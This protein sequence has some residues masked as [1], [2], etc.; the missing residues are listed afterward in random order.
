MPAESV[1]EKTLQEKTSSLVDE[2]SSMVQ[3][4]TSIQVDNQEAPIH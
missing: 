3:M 1:D 2:P 4:D